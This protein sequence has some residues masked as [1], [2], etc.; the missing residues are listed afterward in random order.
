MGTH[1]ALGTSISALGSRIPYWNTLYYILKSGATWYRREINN[2]GGYFK[3]WYSSDAGSTWE[4]LTPGG[5]D[6]TE[7]LPVIDLAH[8][9]THQINGTAYEVLDGAEVI[10]ST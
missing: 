5:L 1:T 9:Y 6:L 10:Y 3:L 2:T 8:I 7:D 4:D